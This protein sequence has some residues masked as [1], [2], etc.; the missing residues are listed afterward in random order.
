VKEEGPKRGSLEQV[1]M[2]L[3]PRRPKQDSILFRRREKKKYGIKETRAVGKNQGV[4]KTAKQPGL[5]GE[6]EKASGKE[7]GSYGREDLDLFLRAGKPCTVGEHVSRVAGT[8][9]F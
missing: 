7:L 5:G 4:R 2:F 6:G 3:P 8:K 9:Q 1:G